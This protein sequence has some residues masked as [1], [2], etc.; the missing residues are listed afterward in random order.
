MILLENTAIITYMDNFFVENLEYD[1]FFSF[2]QKANYKGK[3]VILDYGMNTEDVDRLKKKFDIFVYKC[4]KVMPVFSNRYND[5]PE[6]IDLLDDNITHIMTIDGGDV[7]FQDKVNQIFEESENGI[8]CVEENRIIGEDEFTDYCM[9]KM[10][11][12]EKKHVLDALYGK[13]VKNS[14][15]ICG[16]RED[17]KNICQKIAKDIEVS[18]AEFF[19]IDQIFFNYEWYSL[20][21]YK[22][23]TLNELYNF[24][25]VTNVD[26]YVEKDGCIYTDLG[27]LVTVVH[28]AGANWR[29]LKRSFENKKTDYEQYT[30]VRNIVYKNAMQNI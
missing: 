20:D 6:V 4:D 28:N 13:K 22:K 19:G 7:W 15:V 2:F 25:I 3:I 24:V 17:M 30:Q 14:G 8:G 11:A 18:S 23:V 1:F 16:P 10:S 27:E 5:I 21:D 26:R 9:N 12:D 29:I